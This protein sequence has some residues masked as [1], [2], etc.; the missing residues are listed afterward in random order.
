MAVSNE[1][2]LFCGVATARDSNGGGGGGVLPQQ[3]VCCVVTL[4][5][6]LVFHLD[7]DLS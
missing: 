2:D 1:I 3:C 7:I 6:R 5:A 4:Y